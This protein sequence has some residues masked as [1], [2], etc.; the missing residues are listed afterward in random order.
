MPGTGGTGR[1]N[2]AGRRRPGRSVPTGKNKRSSRVSRPFGTCSI[3]GRT[4][5]VLRPVTKGET[6]T[7]LQVTA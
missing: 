7:L 4:I 6:V 1:S 5:Q 2:A 3:T